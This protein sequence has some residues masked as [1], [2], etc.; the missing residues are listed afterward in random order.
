M[1]STSRLRKVH[2]TTITSAD[3][4]IDTST[5]TS[6]STTYDVDAQG[7]DAGSDYYLNPTPFGSISDAT[8]NDGS[9]IPRTIDSCYFID[10]GTGN[11]PF[12]KSLFFCLDSTSV[13][14]TDE[15]FQKLII[16]GRT[17]VRADAQFYY[18]SQD[19]GSIWHWESI[20][21]DI[22]DPSGN[23]HDL[24]VWAE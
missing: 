6:P 4:V 23:D 24:E 10:Q 17:F 13:P 11:A 21:P 16:D 15:T 18:P 5:T 20:T 7:F 9:G 3:F 1:V 8:F 2:F 22:L 12:D 14:D 19:G